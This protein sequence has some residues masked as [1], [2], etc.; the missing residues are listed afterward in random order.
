[1]HEFQ[2]QHEFQLDLEMDVSKYKVNRNIYDFLFKKC[3]EI[4]V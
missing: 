3:V 1:M 2:I 4:M